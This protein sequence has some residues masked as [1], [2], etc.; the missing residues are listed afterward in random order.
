MKAFFLVM[1]CTQHTG[2]IKVN[3]PDRLKFFQQIMKHLGQQ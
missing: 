3:K 1:G 2:I